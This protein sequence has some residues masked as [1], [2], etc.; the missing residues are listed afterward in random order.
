MKFRISFFFFLILIIK[1]YQAS[2]TYHKAYI[3]DAPG[4]EF[5][6]LNLHLFEAAKSGD[7][8]VIEN[9]LSKGASA[10]ARDRFGNTALLLAARVSKSKSLEVLLA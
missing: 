4:S 5:R 8:K 1:P 3:P 2:S 6:Q 7:T 10:T 9:L